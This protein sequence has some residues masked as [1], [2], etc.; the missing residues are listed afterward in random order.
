M[1]DYWQSKK[2]DFGTIKRN[3]SRDFEFQGTIR[4]PEVTEVRASCGC[5]KVKYDPN[6]RLLKVR[7]D[8]GEIPNHIQGNQRVFK[9][10]DI[11]YKDGSKDILTIEGIKTR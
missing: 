7:F 3:G 2:V 10:I 8:A 9:T 4:I 11:T 6:T 1:T 5:T